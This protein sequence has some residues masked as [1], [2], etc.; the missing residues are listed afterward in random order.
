MATDS[1]GATCFSLLLL[2]A[3]PG[4]LG[5]VQDAWPKAAIVAWA[6]EQSQGVADQISRKKVEMVICDLPAE[7]RQGLLCSRFVAFMP[8]CR[9]LPFSLKRTSPQRCQHFAMVSMM[10]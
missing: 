2:E 4:G 7:G 3:E 6:L 8:I 10:S 5:L 9:W 1:D